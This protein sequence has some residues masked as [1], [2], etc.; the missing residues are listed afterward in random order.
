[1]LSVQIPMVSLVENKSQTSYCFTMNAV[2]SFPNNHIAKHRAKHKNREV[3]NPE[4][5]CKDHIVKL[6]ASLD[7]KTGLDFRTPFHSNTSWEVQLHLF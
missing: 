4:V 3:S 7:G 2:E 1:M 5:L 6:L